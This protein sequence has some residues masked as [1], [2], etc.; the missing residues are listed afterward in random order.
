MQNHELLTTSLSSYV[1]YGAHSNKSQDNHKSKDLKH[2][3]RF[4]RLSDFCGVIWRRALGNIQVASL[5]KS[6]HR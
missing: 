2:E 3:R 4:L 6:D 1:D 5:H